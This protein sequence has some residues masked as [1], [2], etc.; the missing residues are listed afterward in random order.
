MFMKYFRVERECEYEKSTKCSLLF[1]FFL[2][3]YSLMTFLKDFAFAMVPKMGVWFK[4]HLNNKF[5]FCSKCR[6]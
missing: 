1:R 3:I 5:D 2:Y 4:V 6:R